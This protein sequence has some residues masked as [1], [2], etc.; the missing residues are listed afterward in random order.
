M[1]EGPSFFGPGPNKLDFQSFS[2]NLL[3]FQSFSG[4]LLDFSAFWSI[5]WSWAK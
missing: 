5:L 4:N 1:Q 3:D 2:G